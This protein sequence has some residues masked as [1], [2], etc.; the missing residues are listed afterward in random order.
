[1][2]CARRNEQP[3]LRFRSDR[4][5]QANGGWYFHTR[6]GID[7]GPYSTRFDAEVEASMLK[8][9]LR[10]PDQRQRAVDT[11]KEFVADSYSLQ[12]PKATIST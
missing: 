10:Q 3:A 8:A 11:I 9:L 6:E 2:L 7:V 4:V 1:M 12:L 5:F